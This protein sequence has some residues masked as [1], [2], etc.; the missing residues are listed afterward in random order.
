MDLLDRLLEHDQWATN[1]LLEV[2]RGLDAP[3]LDQAF[4]I[5]HRTLRATWDH[6]I[7]NIGVW[8]ALMAGQPV[9]MRRDDRSVAVMRDRHDR[10]YAA[11]AAFARQRRDGQRLDD[12]FM[13]E[14]DDPMI[15]GGAILHVILH[16]AEHRSELLHILERLGVPDL[17]EIDHG[18]WDF[19]RRGYAGE[20]SNVQSPHVS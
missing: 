17:P 11:F 15:F 9:D 13:N 3:Q 12:T 8:T 6:V 14:V 18:L 4:D 2:S 1:Q 19:V 10:A 16:N 5:G 7:F 20:S